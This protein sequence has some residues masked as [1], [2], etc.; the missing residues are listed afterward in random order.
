MKEWTEVSSLLEQLLSA[1]KE[2]RNKIFAD[3]DDIEGWTGLID[4]REDIIKQISK[5]QNQGAIVTN[6]DKERYLQKVYEIDLQVFPLLEKKYDNLDRQSKNI[7]KSIMVGAKYG[8]YGNINPYGAYF[9][10]RN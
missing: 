5:L 2:L 3:D 7:Q 1:S 8:S 10:K 9:D 4:Q 6:E